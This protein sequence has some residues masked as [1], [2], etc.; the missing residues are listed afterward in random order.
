MLLLNPKKYERWHADEKSR[1]AVLKTIEFFEKKGL[2]K[3]KQDDQAAVWYDDF[4]E[5]LKKD[6]TYAL[7]LTPSGY[8]EPDS[9]WDMWRISEYNEILSFYG[10]Q[11]WYSW[12]VSILGLG[13]LWM[14]SNEGLKHKAAAML[15]DGGIFAFGL[16]ER[17]HGADLYSSEMV[18]VPQPDGTY[19]ARGEKY[20]I[21][22]GNKAALVSVF[23]KIEGTGEYVFFAVQSDHPKYECVKK[24]DTSGVR[25]AYVA[26][27]KL[28]DYP[29]TDAE[30]ISRGDLAWESS[31][32]TVNVGKF[33]LGFASIGICTHAFY[34]AINHAAKRVLYGRYVTDFPQVRKGFT[35]AFA[36]LAA[37]KLCG[38]RVADYMKSASDTD[39]RYL[40]FNPIVKMK[41]TSQGEKVVGMLHEIIA[42][43]G[44]EQETWFEMAVRDIGMLPKLE[45]TEQV[46]MALIV[47]FIANYFFGPVDYP[48][49]PKMNAPSNDEYLFHQHTGGLRKVKF[50]DYRKAYAGVDIPNVL[51][52]REQVETFKEILIKAPPTKEQAGNIDYMLAAGELF[53]L[54]AYAQLILENAKIYSIDNDIVNEIFKFLIRDFSAYALNMVTGHENTPDQEA[55]FLK[56]IKKPS[57]DKTSFNNVWEKQVYA[58]LDQ[59]TMN[60]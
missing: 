26:H 44:F 56:M 19:I 42:A 12:Q 27:F 5:F 36:R 43:K 50:P 2:K 60:E 3:L 9:R 22:N 58:L 57:P 18:L 15:K 14:G 52:F 40:L 49:I 16:S 10:L 7:M 6:K 1:Q 24:I 20:Y 32:N 23:G 29:I 45:G 13:P 4:L 39:R 33:E 35:E 47:K 28:N 8:G 55:I 46:N 31:L 38:M 54:I 25:Q 59:Y 17:A 41:V 48:E 37:M 30:I 11:Y 53:T 21:G 34:E 51:I